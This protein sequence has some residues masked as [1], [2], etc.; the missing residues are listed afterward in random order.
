MGNPKASTYGRELL[1]LE[2]KHGGITP[3]QLVD[4]ARDPKS[5]FHDIFEWRDSVAAARYRIVQARK[6]IREIKVSIEYVGSREPQKVAVDIVRAFHS[7]H[8]DDGKSIYVGVRTVQ[9]N[10]RYRT[11]LI[12]EITM[13]LERMA[14]KL[15]VIKNLK[16]YATELRETA[17]RLRRAS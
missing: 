4:E 8:D 7:V 5:I 15:E 3:H 10:E 11:Q 12:Q 1:K 6:F 9:T 17:R 13:E 16:S 14:K 2:K